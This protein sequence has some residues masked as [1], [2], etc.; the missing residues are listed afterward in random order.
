MYRDIISNE[1]FTVLMV[2][3]LT[4]IAVAKL[5]TMAPKEG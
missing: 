1:L 4:I 3:A 2:I 5:D